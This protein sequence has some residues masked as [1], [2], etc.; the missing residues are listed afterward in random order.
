MSI[1]KILYAN[2]AKTTLSSDITTYETTLNVVDGSQFPTPGVGEYFIAT[3]EYG[4]N[5]EIIKVHTRVGNVFS[6][7]E[8]GQEGKPAKAFIAGSRIENRITSY[9]L[10]SYEK[11]VDTLKEVI[12]VDTLD[13]PVNSNST[14]YIC[15]NGDSSGNPITAI[16]HTDTSWRFSTHSTKGA[17]GAAVSGTA[18]GLVYSSLNGLL[19][20][21]LAGKYIIQ[22][23][24]GANTGSCR[25]VTGIGD[26]VVNWGTPLSNPCNPGD[27]FEIYI[28]DASILTD[29]GDTTNSTLIAS[30]GNRSKHGFLYYMGN[31]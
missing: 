28:S 12:S 8:R 4:P 11:I 23:M 16:R 25:V 29:I 7:C 10:S 27:Q 31:F 24:T 1:S 14:T 15:M 20:R 5:V 22:F 9:T 13:T 30:L 3:I 19:F 21:L 26:N 18:T 6:R 17:V 2:N